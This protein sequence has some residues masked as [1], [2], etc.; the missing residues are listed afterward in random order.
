MN[1]IRID[2]VSASIGLYL[3][4]FP[5]LAVVWPVAGGH[6][7]ARAGQVVLGSLC[8]VAGL[9]A[10]GKRRWP[11][12]SFRGTVVPLGL[13]G[14]AVVSVL[15]A[16]S[17]G[18]AGRELALFVGMAA[19]AR[20]VAETRDSREAPACVASIASGTYV[21]VILLLVTA[22]YLTGQ[23]LNRAEI[24]VGYDNYRFFNHVQTAALPASVLAATVAKPRSWQRAV[25][26]FAAIGGFAL[27]FAIMG[28][29]TLVGIA[30]GA[31]AIG[32]MFG[33]L[34]W[35]ILRTLGIAAGLGS[36]AY[37]AVF[38]LLPILVGA[39]TEVAES[40]YGAR[41]GSVEMRI[42]LWRIA[43]S[44]I[45]QS[46]WLGIGPMHYAHHPTGDASHPHNI[47][48][49]IAAE[50]GL[51]VLVL[52]LILYALMMRRLAKAVRNCRDAKQRDCGVGLTL[53][54]TAI[55]VDGLF[56]GNFVMPVSQV[57]IACVFGWAMAWTR[58]QAGGSTRT[59]SAKVRGFLQW[60]TVGLVVTQLWLV[61]SV[62]PE[63][64][65][66]D[67]HIQQAMER[68]PTTTTNPRFWSH[69]WF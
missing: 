5:L 7:L 58:H 35:P 31:F 57:W 60:A 36:L 50:W 63:V 11:V 37:G 56:S 3:L 1:V 17:Q 43:L 6:D 13:T 32:V 29:G 25:A 41:L 39:P 68:F 4:M 10:C 51:P 24:F 28:R 47:Y 14:L 54:C 19:M 26:W 65:H 59:E 46:P 21:A 38:W 30:G 42:Y 49:Q 45:E 12:A 53:A 55:A 64:T 62:W 16:P 18:M 66:L 33:R 44:Y 22:F 52:T 20:V 40:Y 15:R 27:L 9:C 48:L 2:W 61:W 23:S 69:G 67:Q 34:S 8:A